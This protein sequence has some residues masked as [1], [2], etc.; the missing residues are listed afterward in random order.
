MQYM[1]VLFKHMVHYNY[2]LKEQVDRFKE[3][4]DKLTQENK[5]LKKKN[6]DAIVK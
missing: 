3:Q 4:V 5:L 1:Y 6:D 2:R